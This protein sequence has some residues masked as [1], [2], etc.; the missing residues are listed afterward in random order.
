MHLVLW[1]LKHSWS[2]GCREEQF[3]NESFIG[4]HSWYRDVGDNE[5]GVSAW[6]EHKERLT[7]GSKDKSGNYAS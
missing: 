2:A 6:A 1:A 5:A 4:V 7:F 3:V